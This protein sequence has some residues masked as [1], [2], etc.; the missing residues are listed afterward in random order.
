MLLRLEKVK[1]YYGNV[2]AVSNANLSMKE[3]EFVALVGPNGAGKSTLMKTVSGLLKPSEGIIEYDGKS[4]SGLKA[5]QIARMGIIQ[6]PEGRRPFSEMSVKENLLLG[7]FFSKKRYHTDKLLEMVYEL[8]PILKRRARQMAI[9]LSGGEQQMLAIAR[10]LMAEPRLFMIDELSL[11]LAP[12]AVDEIFAKI[13]RIKKNG[14]NILIVEQM[15]DLI[16]DTADK[17]FVIEQGEVIFSGQKAELLK[18][19]RLREVYLGLV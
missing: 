4:I 17:I 13:M 8:F 12:L 5:Y 3:G 9:T 16:M 10:G 11:G 6:C 19:N 2:L 14:M 7:N 18:D 1:V 15:V